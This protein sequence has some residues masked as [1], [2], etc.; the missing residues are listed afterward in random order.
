MTADAPMS[1][2]WIPSLGSQIYAMNGMESEL[3]LKATETGDFTGYTTNINGEGYAKMTF[4]TKVRSEA[5]FELWVAAA[6][7]VNTVLNKAVYESLRTRESVTE[8]R[9]YADAD[10]GMFEHIMGQTGHG[11]MHEGHAE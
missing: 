5:E 6:K 3:N 7:K 4:V 1:A 8:S 2:F 9:T 11:A 10:E